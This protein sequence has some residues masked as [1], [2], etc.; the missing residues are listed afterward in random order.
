MPTCSGEPKNNLI[1]ERK[2]G[3]GRHVWHCCYFHL[4]KPRSWQLS[5]LFPLLC[6]GAGAG[7]PRAALPGRALKA[8]RSSAAARRSRFSSAPRPTVPSSAGGG[9]GERS[10]PTAAA[11][12]PLASP[13]LADMVSPET[14]I[15]LRRGIS[16]SGRRFPRAGRARRPPAPLFPGAERGAGARPPLPLFVCERR[17]E[18][19]R[20]GPRHSAE[21]GA[22]QQ[23][24]AGEQRGRAAVPSAP[25]GRGEGGVRSAGRR[26]RRRQGGGVGGREGRKGG[27]LW[28]RIMMAWCVRPLGGRER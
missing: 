20:A 21:E 5:P 4:S 26:R 11:P 10:A 22:E 24:E 14:R 12:R 18:R 6:G 1:F 3:V 8:A 25:R 19:A 28:R 9:T 16:R 15:P 17:R 7:A 27:R 2:R 13:R 23:R